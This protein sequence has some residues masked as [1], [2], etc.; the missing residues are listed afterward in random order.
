[1]TVESSENPSQVTV[2]T[3]HPLLSDPNIMSGVGLIVGSP[4]G[5]TVRSPHVEQAESNFYV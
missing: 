3:V 1:M 2:V 5:S 4:P